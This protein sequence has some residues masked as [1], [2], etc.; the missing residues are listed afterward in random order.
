MLGNNNVLDLS[1][2]KLN[3]RIVVD[4]GYPALLKINYAIG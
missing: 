4:D 2:W 3:R 1:C